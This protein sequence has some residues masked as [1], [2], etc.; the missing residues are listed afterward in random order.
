VSRTSLLVTIALMLG[1]GA[2]D[3]GP[4]HWIGD[5]AEAK[6]GARAS[7]TADGP[8]LPGAIEAVTV[9]AA[10]ETIG[11]RPQVESYGA[12]LRL[13]LYADPA[14]L[15]D[16]TTSETMLVPNADA[17]GAPVDERTPGMHLGAGT[18]LAEIGPDDHGHTA[19]TIR[20]PLRGD[21]PK[22]GG[23]EVHGYVATATLGKTFTSVASSFSTRPIDVSLRPDVALLD[24][25]NGKPFA[26]I[27]KD[28]Y[29]RAAKLA[30]DGAFTLVQIE[31]SGLV[32]WVASRQVVK[33]GKERPPEDGGELIGS[34]MTT[35]T[36][37]VHTPLYD[38]I[39]GHVIGEA[40]GG[41]AY[42]V[43]DMTTSWERFDVKTSF[44][45]AS[46]WAKL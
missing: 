2:T 8:W 4:Q 25:P 12:G 46:V 22:S 43:K 36:L 17:V 13:W 5:H 15:A 34:A 23:L 41:F 19:V 26:T 6:V 45:I 18:D 40:L 31:Y 11:A 33:L 35:P 29:T 27:T 21:D 37:P 9:L 7:L 28:P 30:R 39:D 10:R 38:A 14:G 16:V 20:W 24:A 42:P 32:G 44:G 1:A 3:A